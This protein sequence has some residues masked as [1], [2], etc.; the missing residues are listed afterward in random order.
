MDQSPVTHVAASHLETWAEFLVCSFW[1]ETTDPLRDFSEG[2]AERTLLLS[3]TAPWGVC[4]RWGHVP[5]NKNRRPELVI[6]SLTAPWGVCTRW[7]YVPG[8]KNRRPE[9]V[10]AGSAELLC[11]TQST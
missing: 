11:A 1:K 3:Q 2:G 6:L 9:V 10:P 7:G 8:N 4:T 5:G